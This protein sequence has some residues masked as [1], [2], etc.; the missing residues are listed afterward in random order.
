MKKE[1][2]GNLNKDI[3]VEKKLVWKFKDLPTA[4]EVANLVD[5]KIITAEEAR[6]MLFKEEVKQ[7]DEVEAL[8]EMVNALQEMVNE[9]ISRSSVQYVPFTKVVEIPSRAN[10][11]WDKYW[12]KTGTIST[13][14]TTGSNGNTVYTMSINQ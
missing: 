13:T 5:M 10:P 14:A 8:K 4:S 2:K 7:S 1:E 12:L 6:S 9:L 3:P 11:Y